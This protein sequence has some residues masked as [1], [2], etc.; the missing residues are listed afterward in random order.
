MTGFAT[1]AGREV[2]TMLLLDV[3]G[4]MNYGTS[5]TDS[6]PRKDIV[7]EAISSIVSRLAK[8]DSQGAHEA[9]GGG[10]RTVTFAGG[11][12][13]DLDDLNPGNLQKKWSSIKWAGGTKIMP[14]MIVVRRTHARA[15]SIHVLI[16]AF[17]RALALGWK[18][19]MDV[20]NEEFGSRPPA[21]QPVLMA[22]VITDGEADDVDQLISA[23]SH[24]P[25]HFFVVFAIVGYGDEAAGVYREY[26]NL[27]ARNQQVRALSFSAETDPSKIANALIQL[28]GI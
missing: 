19:L 28:S 18:M 4:S 26:A 20:Y 16:H 17:A 27:A 24:L 23:L 14:G 2:E 11:R 22:L 21:A 5:D 9:E 25:S 15:R 13:T 3:T 6:T 7:R 1:P 12:A 10:L 8:L